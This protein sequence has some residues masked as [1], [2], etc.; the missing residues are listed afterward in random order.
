MSQ[1]TSST[2][3]AYNL[4][5][6][7]VMRGIR[8]GGGVGASPLSPVGQLSCGVEWGAKGRAALGPWSQH[9][10][11]F[12]VQQAALEELLL[13]EVAVIVLVHFGEDCLGPL[14]SAVGRAA[15]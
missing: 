4:A 5:V 13:G 9:L 7:G 14:L 8:G 2:G 10:G 11:E 6:C 15:G 1:A 12:L 3:P